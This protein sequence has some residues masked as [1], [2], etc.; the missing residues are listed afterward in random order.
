V[1]TAVSRRGRI[2]GVIFVVLAVGLATYWR[3]RPSPP[4][5]QG[6]PALALAVALVGL[7]RTPEGGLSPDQVKHM[8]PLLRVLRDIDPNDV[9]ASRA[10]TEEIRNLLTPEQRAAIARRREEVQA[11]RQP[12]QAP[13]GAAG[14]SRGPLG[15]GV[16]GGD[17]AALRR[18]IFTL[19]IERLQSRLLES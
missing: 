14:G 16:S 3:L 10:M 9:A 5:L 17:R 11:Q 6:D 19:L 7:D 4:P 13:R 15:P 8:L 12:G 1:A 2:L 18:Q